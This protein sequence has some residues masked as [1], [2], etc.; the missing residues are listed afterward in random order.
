M[1][2]LRI[3]RVHV[4]GRAAD[5]HHATRAEL[6]SRAVRPPARRVR[7]AAEPRSGDFLVGRNVSRATSRTRHSPERLINADLLT[8]LLAY[9]RTYSLTILGLLVYLLTH[10]LTSLSS[11]CTTPMRV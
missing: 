2:L 11:T 6:R 8:Y 3:C 1:T 10:L 9:L 7:G 5:T 4:T